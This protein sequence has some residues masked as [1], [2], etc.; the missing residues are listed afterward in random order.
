MSDNTWDLK[1]SILWSLRKIVSNY[2]YPRE[3]YIYNSVYREIFNTMKNFFGL[4]IKKCEKIKIAILQCLSLI[5]ILDSGRIYQMWQQMMARNS[6]PTYNRRPYRVPYRIESHKMNLIGFVQWEFPY[7]IRSYIRAG[8]KEVVVR[9][10]AND[11]ARISIYN[12]V[13]IIIT[14]FVRNFTRRVNYA[15]EIAWHLLFWRCRFDVK[16]THVISAR[17][18]WATPLAPRY[19][20]CW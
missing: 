7:K 8:K 11:I 4:R 20:R 15:V 6:A 19:T 12:S 2:N 13:D 18:L 10:R 14:D 3:I 5:L 17:A 1:A 9:A 16:Q